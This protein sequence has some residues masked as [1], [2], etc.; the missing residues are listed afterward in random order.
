MTTMHLSS[1]ICSNS[2][3]VCYRRAGAK[4]S[5]V[6]LCNI[7]GGLTHLFLDRDGARPEKID[8]PVHRPCFSSNFAR[9]VADGKDSQSLVALVDS[10]DQNDAALCENA[11]ARHRFFEIQH[12]HSICI[13]QCISPVVRGAKVTHQQEPLVLPA[14]E[15]LY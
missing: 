8:V 3:R 11:F 6:N 5:S 10:L 12:D 9:R 2:F 7:V 1:F 4:V 15:I 13:F 14:S